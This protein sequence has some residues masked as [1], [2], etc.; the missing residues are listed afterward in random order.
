MEVL[1]LTVDR[2]KRQACI[3]KEFVPAHEIKTNKACELCLIFDYVISKY[4][5]SLQ[6]CNLAVLLYVSFYINKVK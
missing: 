4:S 6:S 2:M 5:P 3:Y 1:A